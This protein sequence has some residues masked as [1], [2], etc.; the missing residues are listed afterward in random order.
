MRWSRARLKPSHAFLLDDQ[1]RLVHEATVLRPSVF[2]LR[3]A[4][5][6]PLHTYGVQ[7][8][9]RPFQEG[10][11]CGLPRVGELA[12]IQGGEQAPHFDDLLARA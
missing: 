8:P 12:V 3:D 5:L 9:C 7:T 6:R 11:H 1:R 10:G 4:T 2:G